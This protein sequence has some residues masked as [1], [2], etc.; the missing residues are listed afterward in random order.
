MQ[1]WKEKGKR[2]LHAPNVPIKS[3]IN[4]TRLNY[5]I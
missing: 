4:E 5:E 3:V 2:A 1:N